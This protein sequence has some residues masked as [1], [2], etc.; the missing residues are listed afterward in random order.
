[1]TDRGELSNLLTMWRARL[2]PAT[3]GL[4]AVS[5]RL[6]GLRREEVA[7][8]AGLSVDYLVR[9]EQGRSHHPSV[10]V[11]GALA[12]A[13]QLSDEERDQLFQAA[14]LPIPLAANVP[15]HIPRSVQRLLL[16]APDVAIGVYTMHWTLLTVNASW[17]ALLGR[18][19]R[20]Y[21][22]IEAQ[23]TGTAP[24][25][26]MSES[27]IERFERALVTDMR[28]AALRYPMDRSVQQLLQRLRRIDRF[29]GLW[30][31]GTSVAQRS[32]EKTF[33]H[34]V[35]GSITVDCDVYTTIG[36]DLRIITYTV[37]PGS[38]DASK[39]DLARTLGMQ[40]STR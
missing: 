15:T 4:P 11:A 37:E 22:L 33:L 13:L 23:F 12:R 20:D 10:Q 2:K 21:N 1:M 19:P 8:L 3:V 29:E 35:V 24:S 6:T 38:S 26:L 36:T 7:M 16:R 30:L 9:L 34:P 25:V 18:P 28:N 17:Q 31:E 14:G 5:A 32:E 27:Y 39:Y 40:Q